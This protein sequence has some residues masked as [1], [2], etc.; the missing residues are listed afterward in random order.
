M[1]TSGAISIVKGLTP[2]C[3]REEI[4]KAWQH[5]VDTGTVWNMGLRYSQ[6]AACMIE[7]GTLERNA[8]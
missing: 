3:S 8:A 5:L 1:N 7:A 6:M 2:D 4:R